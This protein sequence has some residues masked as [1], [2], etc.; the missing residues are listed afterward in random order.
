MSVEMEMPK[1]LWLKKH[2]NPRK[3]QDCEFY[4]LVDALTHLATGGKSCSYCSV[5]C[6][7]GYLA[8]GTDYGEEG[9][10]LDFFE[11]GWPRGACY[12]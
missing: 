8:A 2:M 11:A 9:W 1:I 6:K 5:I 3:F 7:Q 12:G 4:D 10:Q